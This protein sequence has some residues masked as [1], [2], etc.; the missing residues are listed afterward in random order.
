MGKQRASQAISKILRLFPWGSTG[1]L[2]SE[3]KSTRNGEKLHDSLTTAVHRAHLSRNGPNPDSRRR[4]PAPLPRGSPCPRPSP[5]KLLALTSPM[6]PL[7]GRLGS[8]R[9]EGRRRSRAST[10][11]TCHIAYVSVFSHFR[12]RGQSII[13]KQFVVLEPSR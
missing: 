10:A 12:H 6:R 13:F 7:P 1:N 2:Q 11:A 4:L 8:G 9:T 3:K 5:N